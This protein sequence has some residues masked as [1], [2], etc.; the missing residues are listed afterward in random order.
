M[1]L[2]MMKGENEP[3]TQRHFLLNVL[4]VEGE[5]QVFQSQSLFQSPL[6][7]RA[8]GKV[9]KKKLQGVHIYIYLFSL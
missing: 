6:R 1:I 7:L 9:K 8:S 4:A 5:N 3:L 2:K